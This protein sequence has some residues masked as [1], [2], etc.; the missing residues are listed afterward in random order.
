LAQAKTVLSLPADTVSDLAAK[1]ATADIVDD[2]VSED[3]DKPLSAAQ[4]KVLQDTKANITDINN[5]I[6]R[7]AFSWDNTA[8]TT[9]AAKP[10]VTPTAE[11]LASVHGRMKGCLLL[12][13]GSVNYYLNPTDWTQKED[14]SASDLT[15]ADGMVM[16][17]IPRFYVRNS[18]AGNL[19]KPEISATP[20]AGYEVHP[21]FI[22]DGVEVPFRYISAYDAC[23]QKTQAIT[24]ATAADPVVI[25]SNNHGLQTGDT[26]TITGVVGMV[27]INDRTFTVTR[28]DANEFSLDS[29]DGTLH[30]AYTSGGTFAAAIG[31]GNLDNA[32]ALVDLTA[33]TGSKLAS[34]SGAYPMVGL[35]RSEFRTLAANRGAGWRQL[36]FALWSAIGL[37]LAVEAQ[38]L[39]SQGVYGAGNTGLA[40][41]PTASAVQT[42]SPHSKA[43]KGNSIGNASTDTTSGASSASRDVAFCKYRGIEN[44]WGNCLN[45]VDGIVTYSE[46][47]IAGNKVFAYWSNNRANFADVA[48]ASAATAI[49]AGFAF[50]GEIHNTLNSLVRATVFNP[51]TVWALV[52][53]GGSATGTHGTTDTYRTN[54]GWR[55]VRV[56]GSA[57]ATA[58]AGAFAFNNFDGDWVVPLRT[59]GSR[60]AY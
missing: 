2:L 6:P 39:D 42:D 19:W 35:Q 45:L 10:Q 43:G 50:L 24:G 8:T 21:A 22:K 53:T 56:G 16:V 3:T 25:T 4:G 30:T 52:P 59:Q 7:A 34:I 5:L 33:T 15:G 32:T 57:V 58:N 12:D 41:Y 1:V 49:P 48:N 27:E 11:M 31:G 51:L 9:P 13:G 29:E 60:L 14:G 20:L 23:V 54:S 28:V 38:T 37:L 17:E 36:D 18:S 55:A 26:C 44:F 46:G 47:N 40:S